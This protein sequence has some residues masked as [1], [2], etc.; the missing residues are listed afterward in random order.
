[1]I[2]EKNETR[3]VIDISITGNKNDMISLL[4]KKVDVTPTRALIIDLSKLEELTPLE[5]VYDITVFKITNNLKKDFENFLAA[6]DST[7]T[8]KTPE[9]TSTYRSNMPSP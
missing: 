6:L 2:A 7:L 4:G 9:N 5:K 8:Q 3:L 1:M